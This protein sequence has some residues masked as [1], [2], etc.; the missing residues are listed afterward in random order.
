MI[1]LVAAQE[2]Y[3]GEYNLQNLA[4]ITTKWVAFDPTADSVKL[5]SMLGVPLAASCIDFSSSRHAGLRAYEKGHIRE[6]VGAGASMAM[7]HI[8]TGADER[9]IINTIDAC[10]EELVPAWRLFNTKEGS[11]T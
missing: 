11:S 9:R 4:V 6:G 10:Y 5:A 2:R 7:V 8:L 3:V 1:L